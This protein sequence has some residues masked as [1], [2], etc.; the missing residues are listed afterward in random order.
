MTYDNKEEQLVEVKSRAEGEFY[1]LHPI[2]QVEAFS[3][4]SEWATHR[5][6]TVER[7]NE[8]DGVPDRAEDRPVLDEAE[9]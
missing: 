8:R 1:N 3:E 4:L 2:D 5:R 9:K 6:E 7:V